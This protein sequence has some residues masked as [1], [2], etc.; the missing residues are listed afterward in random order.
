MKAAE[1]RGGGTGLCLHLS[2]P[3]AYGLLCPRDELRSAALSL[4]NPGFLLCLQV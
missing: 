4:F 1:V 3:L 2:P